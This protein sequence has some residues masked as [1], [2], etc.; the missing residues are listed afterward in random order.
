MKLKVFTFRFSESAAGFDDA[1]LQQFVADKEIVDVNQHFF[2]HEKTPYLTV[3]ISYRDLSY[4]ERR[5]NDRR[6][7]PRNDLDPREKGAFDALRAWRL[8]RAGQEGIPPL[9]DR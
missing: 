4:E 5:K 1:P 6:Q 3:I 8:A 2:I 9:H 7:D